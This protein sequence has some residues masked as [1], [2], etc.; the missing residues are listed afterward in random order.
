MHQNQRSFVNETIILDSRCLYLPGIFIALLL[1]CGS[2]VPVGKSSA[3]KKTFYVSGRF[4]YSPEGEKV[5]LRGVNNMNVVSDKTG[6]KSFPEIAKTG[7]NVVRIM[8]MS[9]GGGGDELDVLIGN[10]IKNK[11]IPLIELHDATGKWEMLDSTVNFWVRPDV[12][13]V[14]VKYEKYLLLNIANEAGTSAVA[15]EEFKTKYS[16]AVSKI[17]A[18]GINVPLMI[19][20]A[21]WG[22]NEA[23]LLQNA[24]ALVQNDPEHNLLFSWHIWDSGIAESRIEKAVERS[25]A[26]NIALVIGEFAPMEVKCKCCIPYKFIMQYCQQ[27]SIGWLAWSWGPGNSDCAQMDMTKTV[28]FETLYNWGL[29]VAITDSYSIKNTA[30]RPA[31]FK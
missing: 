8:W 23:Y 4:L 18:A 24:V 12:R 25:V 16:A 13:D 28:A 14:L 2:I 21:N 22:R 26:L 31:I 5:S 10:C 27:Q 1:S 29:E 3:T 17:R 30:V 19:D 9:W 11:M 7:A 20:A 15:M 6:E